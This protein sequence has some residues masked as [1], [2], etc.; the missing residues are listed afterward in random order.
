M[1]AIASFNMQ[2]QSSFSF[3]L[4]PFLFESLHN[5]SCFQPIVWREI[6]SSVFPS[7]SELW[8]TFSLSD[9]LKMRSCFGTRVV[10]G[11]ASDW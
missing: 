10:D 6:M 5:S 7:I 11:A 9:F 4:S 2:S 1:H 3:R 8:S